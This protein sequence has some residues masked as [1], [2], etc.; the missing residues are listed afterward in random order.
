VCGRARHAF[1]GPHRPGRRPVMARTHRF[2]RSK[3][4]PTAHQDRRTSALGKAPS[5][6][7]R[8]LSRVAGSTIALPEE[9]SQEFLKKRNPRGRPRVAL[10]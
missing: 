2:M 4:A 8:T 7:C 6:P 9:E 10:T 1:G 5:L 3:V